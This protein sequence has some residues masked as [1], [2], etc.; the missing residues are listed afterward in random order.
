[1]AKPSRKISL[2]NGAT[3]MT[4]RMTA[5]SLR[6]RAGIMKGRLS[7][8]ASQM[9]PSRIRTARYYERRIDNIIF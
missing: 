2:R 9:F 1:M 5:N 8:L 6:F 3:A 4:A 7:L